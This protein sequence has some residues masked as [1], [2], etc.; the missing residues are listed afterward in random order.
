MQ[1]TQEMQKTQAQFLGWEDPLEEEMDAC[2]SSCLQN[3]MDRRVWQATVYGVANNRTL[4]ERLS[5]ACFSILTLF[6]IFGI[7]NT[8]TETTVRAVSSDGT[9]VWF[10]PRMS[11]VRPSHCP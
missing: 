5:I 4:T 7:N 1:E 9:S 10:T 3:P 8:S 6:F 2:S 11:G